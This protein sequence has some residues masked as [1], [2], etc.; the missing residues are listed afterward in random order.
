M[1][2]RGLNGRKKEKFERTIE[3]WIKEDIL[4]P[5]TGATDEGI[6]SL[7][8]VEQPTKNKIRPV[9]D[10]RELNQYVECHTGDDSIDICNE[11]LREWRQMD[12]VTS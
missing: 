8:A 2:K 11:T 12:G 7:L 6:I 3:Q 1:Y 10:F 5:W 9:F 4:V